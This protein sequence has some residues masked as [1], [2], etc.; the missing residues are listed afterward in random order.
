MAWRASANGIRGA[1]VP[2][3]ADVPGEDPDLFAMVWP[4]N[5]PVPGRFRLGLGGEAKPRIDRLGDRLF[6]TTEARR[7]ALS[8]S[9]ESPP[10][11]CVQP[12]W[13]PSWLRCNEFGCWS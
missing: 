8:P 3:R 9:A 2:N 5:K 11:R 10:I 12:P 6:D 4:G 1:E 7:A 13:K